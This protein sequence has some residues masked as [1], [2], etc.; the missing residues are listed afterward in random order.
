MQ[1][2][3]LL[4]WVGWFFFVNIVFSVIIQASYLTV[5]P[6]LN[7]VYG[8]TAS[9][10]FLAYFFLGVSYIAHATIINS[11]VGA[12]VF[13]IAWLIPQRVLV[14][15]LATIVSLLIIIAEV[16][17]RIT[18]RLYHAHQFS[19]GIT[20]L[21]SGVAG[22]EIPLSSLEYVFLIGLIALIVFLQSMVVWLVWRWVKRSVEQNEHRH[23]GLIAGVLTACVLISY[24]MMAFVVSVPQRY[25]FN[26]VDSHLLLKMA[27]LVPYY[28]DVYTWII[29]NA[30]YDYHVWGMGAHT[31]SVPTSDLDKP[32]HYPLHPIQCTP[33]AKKLNVLFLVFDTLRYDAVNP[34][35][36]PN[37]SKFAQQAIQFDNTYSGGNC[38]QPGVFSMFY[39]LPSNYWQ[40]TITQAKG[41]VLISQLKQAGYQFGIFTSASLTFPAFVN[42]I[43]VNIHSSLPGD[44]PGDSS[45]ARDIKITQ[46][47][48]NFVNKR[49][50]NKP[51]FSFVFY[52][53]VHNYCEGSASRNMSP[54]HPAIG[55][56]ARFSL[57]ADTDPRPYINRYHNAAYFVDQQA[58]QILQVLKDKQL[59]KNTIVIITA[60][61]GEQQNDQHMGYWSHAS[62]Y[63]PYQLHIPMIVYWPGMAP[64][65]KPY[66]VSNFDLAPT[67]MQKVLNC[68]N[69]L[70]D[71]TVGHSLFTPGNRPFLIDGSYT[72]YAYVTPTQTIRVYPGGDYVLESPLGHFQYRQPL[73]IPLLKQAGEQ[74]SRY[75]QQ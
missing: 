59:L 2:S 7:T 36:M 1:K 64:Q 17:D 53:T 74:L 58:A 13:V 75:Y 39:G 37:V 24:A 6:E 21:K 31:V 14:F 52:D 72:D 32:M 25:R 23:G 69:P 33:P 62:A 66:F 3:L 38:T 55:E 48:K 4:R 49:D 44:T 26:D 57:N 45:M 68:S 35:V 67:L 27:R 73:N 60:D 71:Y 20:I 70:P 56:C 12:L 18:Y 47:F 30:S 46:Y 19:I 9:N 43:F 54:F 50:P 41:P 15:P 22:E 16:I 8:S 65:R 5:M 28:Q 42:N 10:I 61:H 63:T 29:P 51:F 11:V 40:S 34:V